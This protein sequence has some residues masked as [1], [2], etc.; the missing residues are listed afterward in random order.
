MIVKAFSTHTH[1]GVTYYPGQD[2]EMSHDEKTTYEAL[3]I[4][5]RQVEAKK[6]EEIVALLTEPVPIEPKAKKA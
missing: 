3:A 4:G 2:M 1:N 5:Q 6:A